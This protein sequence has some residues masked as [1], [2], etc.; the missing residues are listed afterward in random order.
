[1]KFLCI[2]MLIFLPKISWAES[3]NYSIFSD[4]VQYTGS[5]DAYSSMCVKNF[6]ANI[7][8]KELFVLIKALQVNAELNEQ[9][10][11]NLRD[12]YFRIRK[13]TLSQLTQ[14]GLAKKK[15]LCGNYLKV[16]NRFD[17]KKNEALDKIEVLIN[18]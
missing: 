1:M 8:E 9:E 7:A 13:S 14:L 12:K 10:I 4:L 11:F 16:F 2:L 3:T 18:E 6:Q 17:K 5:L 15:N